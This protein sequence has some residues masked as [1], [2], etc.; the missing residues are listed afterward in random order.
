MHCF[1]INII[2]SFDVAHEINLLEAQKQLVEKNPDQF[3]ITRFRRELTIQDPPL[4]VNLGVENWQIASSYLHTEIIAK[5]WAYGVI[6]LSFKTTVTT[7]SFEELADLVYKLEEDPDLEARGISYIESLTK[8]LEGSI[9]KLN[10][11]EEVEDYTIIQFISDKGPKDLPASFTFDKLAQLLEGEKNI[12]FS[13]QTLEQVKSNM[14]QYSDEDLIVI[15]WNRAVIMGDALEVQE[16][17]WIVEYALGQLLELRYY[18]HH[19]DL[20]LSSLYRKIQE[21]KPG[22]LNNPYSQVSREAA[23]YF[24]E[25]SDVLDQLENSLKVI[26]DTYYAKVYRVALDRFFIGSWRKTLSNK[27][28]NLSNISSLFANDINEKR[29][30]LMELIIIILI[31]IEVVP[32][33]MSLVKY[34]K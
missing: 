21:K 13:A 24:I 20:K 26:G 9:R 22:L 1:Y 12:T 25:I 10:I 17:S 31:A 6:S 14:Y 30:Q 8:T 15:D 19:I 27:L 11:W 34:I 18:D 28:Q 23:A 2:R 33:V 29:N 32:F 4:V 16:L 3:K 5:I 7:D